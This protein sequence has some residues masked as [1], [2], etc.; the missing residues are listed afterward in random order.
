MEKEICP[1][2][3]ASEFIYKENCRICKYC[4]SK[5][6][7]RKKEKNKNSITSLQ[8]DID[9]LLKKCIDEPWNAQKYAGLILDID[10]TNEKAMMYF[11]EDVNLW[12]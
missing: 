10:P 8:N 2:C 5:F 7:E 12:R 1:N 3:G 6:Y 9:I 4:D 11:I